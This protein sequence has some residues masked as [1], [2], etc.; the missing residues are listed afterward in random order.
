MQQTPSVSLIIVHQTAPPE[1]TG[2]D[3]DPHRAICTV[4]PRYSM[5]HPVDSD[6]RVL[7]AGFRPPRKCL[8]Y[9]L[10]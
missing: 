2:L 5:C 10:V 1:Q 3:P 4:F 7:R 8:S 9:Q 6:V